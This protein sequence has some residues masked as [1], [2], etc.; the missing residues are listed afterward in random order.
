M[1]TERSPW[2]RASKDAW[3]VQFGGKQVRL[4]KGKDNRQEA[5]TA[6][7]K[8][9]TT[10][11][12]VPSATKI[13]TVQ[14]CDLFLQ[15]SEK[16]HE[17]S[18]FDWH[19]YFLASFC[20]DPQTARLL[21]T[22]LKPFHCTHWLDSHPGWKGA[23]RSAIGV[24]KRAFSWAEAEGIIPTNP[25]KRIKK[26]AVGCRSRVLSADERRQIHEAIDDPKFGDFVTALEETGCRP[27]E[28]ARVTAADVDLTVGV[29]VLTKH[30]TAKKTGEPR[31]IYLTPKMVDLTTRLIS[32]VPE[33]PLF[34][35]K[36]NRP[37]S[38]NAIR[39]R[40]RRLREK[41]PQLG[42]FIS[43]TFRTTY[44]TTALENGVGVAQVA[45]LL[46][47][48]STDMVMRHYGHLNQKVKHMREMAAKA[49]GLP[50]SAA[51][52]T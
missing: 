40:F 36:S 23:R 46:G 2:Y 7:Y 14:V 44:A 11:A 32:T 38:K 43:Y 35:G 37:F 18:T 51:S 10:T 29:W 41:L 22:E 19:K 3:F 25:F 30:K 26:P 34:R 47:H 27:S 28:V 4:A 48:K 21:A 45:E 24:L 8:L 9:M 5:M 13:L 31:V 15:W 49:S 52:V 33:G 6:F 42:N 16:H 1:A 12:D 17:K 20:K 39:C 50:H